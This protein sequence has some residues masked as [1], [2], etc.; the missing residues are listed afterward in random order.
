MVIISGECTLYVV[1]LDY[2][3]FWIFAMPYDVPGQRRKRFSS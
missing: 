2:P 1:H 3:A